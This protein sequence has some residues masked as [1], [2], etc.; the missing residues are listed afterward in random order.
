LHK[1]K[2]YEKNMSITQQQETGNKGEKIAKNYLIQKGFC[3]LE[4]NWRY[5]HLEIDIIAQNQTFIVFCEVKTRSSN[6]IGEPE[7]FVS[8]QQQRNIIRAANAYIN[9]NSIKKEA[10]FDIIS[11]LKV[12]QKVDIKHLEYA[13]SP[14]W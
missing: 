2:E 6:T 8:R 11:I 13:F 4:S 12:N 7:E 10:R 14:H 5:G 1:E 3:I 9:K